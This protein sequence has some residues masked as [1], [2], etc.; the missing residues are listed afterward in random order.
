MGELRKCEKQCFSR[1]LNKKQESSGKFW[2]LQKTWWK[3]LMWRG[4]RCARSRRERPAWAWR[5]RVVKGEA[6]GEG[7]V[8]ARRVCWDSFHRTSQ[9]K[10]LLS[11]TMW[12][13]MHFQRVFWLFVDWMGSRIER[14]PLLQ[15]TKRRMIIS[16]TSKLTLNMK[17]SGLFELHAGRRINR[18]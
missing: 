17:L 15:E 14:E 4:D 9:T 8:R 7:G 1:D 13:N 2:V 18:W 5:G 12:I 3:Q 16:W 6:R 11:G 10:I